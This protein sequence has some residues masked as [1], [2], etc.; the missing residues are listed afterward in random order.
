MLSLI[1]QKNRWKH[2][3]SLL[4]TT[5]SS[6]IWLW[7][8]LVVSE[9]NEIEG[10]F[11]STHTFQHFTDGRLLI[12]HSCCWIWR[13]F[14]CTGMSN[15]EIHRVYHHLPTQRLLVSELLS[16]GQLETQIS[17]LYFNEY[18]R[19]HSWNA[20]KGVY[21]NIHWVSLVISIV[22][23]N[24]NLKAGGPE[25]GHGGILPLPTFQK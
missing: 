9:A 13:C 16:D 5:G 3:P 2:F 6:K 25:W 8:H 20:Q 12:S 22:I 18:F 7:H 23:I 15:T 4:L 14:R 21:L 10:L 17:E 24:T 11:Q 19:T 1:Y